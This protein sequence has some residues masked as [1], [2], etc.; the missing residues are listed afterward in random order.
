[1][2]VHMN[3]ASLFSEENEELLVYALHWY[4]KDCYIVTLFLLFWVAIYNTITRIF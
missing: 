4:D 2:A 1:M 3:N